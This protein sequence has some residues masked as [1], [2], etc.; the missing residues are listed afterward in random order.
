M[1]LKLNVC[2]CISIFHVSSFWTRFD[3]S[4]SV[5]TLNNVFVNRSTIESVFVMFQTAFCSQ[6]PFD[7]NVYDNLKLDFQKK[8]ILFE[9]GLIVAQK[10]VLFSHICLI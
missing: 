8:F 1:Y 9:C 6:I 7:S 2:D 5:R 4:P 10:S 3:E